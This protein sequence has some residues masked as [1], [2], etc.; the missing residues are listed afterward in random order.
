MVSAA[1]Q[2]LLG[3]GAI[4]AVASGL[5]LVACNGI[6]G[7]GEAVVD[8]SLEDAGPEGGSDTI[9]CAAYCDLIDKSCTGQ[10]AEYI[11]R[12]VC[13]EMC[14]TFDPGRVGDTTT[15]SLAC[16]YG[17][18]QQAASDPA[19]LCQRAGPLAGGGCADP[20][21][22]FCLLADTLC[23]PNQLFPYDGGVTECRAECAKYIYL[24]TP[25][26]GA[27]SGV[28]DTSLSDGDTLNCRLYHLESAY[29]PVTPKALKTHCPHTG[30]D[31]AACHK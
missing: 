4:L 6:L 26:A 27:D 3:Y 29:D 21:N 13:V 19:T 9:A 18:A 15:D 17:R 14:Q 11:S 20:C 1:R 31:S 23:E 10:N 25:D 2:R 7:I 5:G 8:P 22:A 24:L 30:S 12:A 16:R 28:G